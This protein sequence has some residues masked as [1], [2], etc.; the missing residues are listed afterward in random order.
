MRRCRCNFR[1]DIDIELYLEAG[2][3]VIAYKVYRCWVSEFQALP[4]LDANFSGTAIQMITLEH[5]G[6]ERD[7]AVVEPKET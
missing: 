1:K 7:P 2:Q 4:E 3:L 5:E 6:W